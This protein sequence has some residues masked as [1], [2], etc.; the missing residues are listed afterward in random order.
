MLNSPT[1]AALLAKTGQY[2]P[3]KSHGATTSPSSS[4]TAPGHFK[5]SVKKINLL[6]TH[7]KR[8]NHTRGLFS[9]TWI[10]R[11]V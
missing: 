6:C 3:Y 2:K 11:L 9:A 8:A 4:S 1:A 7:C 5:K 10:S